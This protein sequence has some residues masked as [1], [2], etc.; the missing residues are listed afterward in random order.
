MSD[1][2]TEAV[3]QAMQAPPALTAIW[4]WLSGKDV[5]FWTG[6]FG[7]CFIAIQAGYLV[8]KWRRDI[9]RDRMNFPPIEDK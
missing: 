5:S 2:R 9:R 6:I 4:L 1:H 8:W 7:I 3:T